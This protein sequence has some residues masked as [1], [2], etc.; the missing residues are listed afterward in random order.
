MNWKIATLVVAAALGLLLAMMA[1]DAHGKPVPPP[2]RCQHRV[3]IKCYQPGTL[4]AWWPRPPAVPTRP[5]PGT[6]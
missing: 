3:L 1:S 6:R 2:Y 5:A 4:P